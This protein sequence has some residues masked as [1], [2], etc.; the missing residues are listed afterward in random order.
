MPSPIDKPVDVALLV[1]VHQIP[2]VP[3]SPEPIRADLPVFEEFAP[4]R[5]IH[6]SPPAAEDHDE[7]ESQF[8]GTA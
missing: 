6:H 4:G 1:H 8:C 2:I 5:L 7:S 3:L